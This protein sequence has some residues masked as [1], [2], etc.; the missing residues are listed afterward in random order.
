MTEDP[1]RVAGYGPARRLWPSRGPRLSH[2][3]YVLFRRL[4]VPLEGPA[5]THPRPSVDGSPSVRPLWGLL[6]ILRLQEAMA[7]RLPAPIPA[8]VVAFRLAGSPL[9]RGSCP[10]RARSIP[11]RVLRVWLLRGLPCCL[12]RPI[13]GQQ[14]RPRSGVSTRGPSSCLGRTVLGEH[15]TH[16]ERCK[17]SA[18]SRRAVSTYTLAALIDV[19]LLIGCYLFVRHYRDRRDWL[20]VLSLIATLLFVVGSTYL[21]LFL[22]LGLP[23]CPDGRW[24]C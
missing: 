15:S 18:H 2:V 5:G 1:G 20:I 11:R 7:V 9:G 13:R 14:K 17:T 24:A 16:L 23:G 19:P 22:A 21:L 6:P 8:P 4:R 3:R 12:D 10:G